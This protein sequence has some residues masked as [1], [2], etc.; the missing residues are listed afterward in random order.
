[1]LVLVD[2][3]SRFK[4]VYFLKRK[5]EAPACIRKFVASF[6]ALLNRKQAQPTAVVGALH[7]DNAGEFTSREFT[8]FL[9]E[10]LITATACPPHVHALNG[11]AER[12]I[13]TIME[14]TRA[15]I[16]ASGAPIGFWDYAVDHAVDILNRTTCPPE[17]TQTSYELVTGDAP[18]VMSILPWG[19]R[20]YAVKP[21]VAYSKTNIDT[22]AWV[23]QM[24]G[25]SCFSPG[26][27][28][29]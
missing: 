21:R 12:A 23:G 19:C 24:L 25:R 6:T 18:R 20:T 5:S 14:L 3:H 10:S 1:L 13:R 15:T 27:Y 9:D 28:H 11:V 26:A 17:S 8:E 7:T 2:D 22:H 16:H 29:V 4:S